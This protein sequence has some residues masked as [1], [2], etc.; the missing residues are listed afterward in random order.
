ML[1]LLASAPAHAAIHVEVV[2]SQTM[3]ATG[4]EF[5]VTLS[6]TASGSPFNAVDFVLGYDP[7][8]FALLPATPSTSQEG[9]LMTGGCSNACGNS[10]HRFQAAG[11][12]V[13]VTDVLLC[14]KVA[15]TGPGDLYRLRFRALAG[16]APR[17]TIALRRVRF[18]N[19]G[20][21]VPDVT[22]ESVTIL[23]PALLAVGDAPRNAGALRA[24]PN[25]SRG[26]VQLVVAGTGSGVTRLEILDAQGRIVRRMAPLWTTAGARVEWDGTDDAGR[27][28]P[29]GV[30]L[31]RFSRNGATNTSR[32]VR[33]R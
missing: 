6:L 20:L 24:E 33:V 16:R 13:V 22:A 15:V 1:A 25:P 7:Q 8:A 11:D 3:V 2:P 12:S 17:S 32:L 5:D 26:R 28:T 9:C 19:A 30:Y 31:A 27:A 14:S 18:S 29:D 23:D 10:F 4:Q 21:L